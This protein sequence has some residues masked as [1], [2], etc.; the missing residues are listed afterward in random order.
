MD[1]LLK[2]FVILITGLMCCCSIHAQKRLSPL[3]AKTVNWGFNG[4]INALSTTHF[5]VYQGDTKLEDVSY[6][7]KVGFTG[8]AFFRINLSNF[9]MQPEVTYC[10]AQ[11]KFSFG[12][13]TD[14]GSS[15]LQTTIN[16]HY[17]SLLV[18]VLAG[19]NIIKQNHYLFNVYLGPD[20]QYHY[21]TSFDQ[22]N[23]HFIDKSP[24][25]SIN[26]IIGFSF[27]ISNLFFDFR[28]E[29]NR[30]NTD[31]YFNDITEAPEYLKDIS[32]KKNENILSFSC[33][34]MF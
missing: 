14:S 30:P 20:F 5:S 21:R 27:N 8:G 17:Q 31:I 25:Y 23:T 11:E 18:P 28:Y 10:F 22:G 29:I 3:T 4:G 32:V 12:R 9:F 24:R 13:L 7:N 16:T 6:V 2:Y 1:R 33:G 26:G 15:S 19:Y 34:L